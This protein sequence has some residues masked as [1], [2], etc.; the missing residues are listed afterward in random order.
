MINV[1]I[2]D[3]SPVVREFLILVLSSDPQV[4]IIGT[5][6]NGVEALEAASSKKPDV[7]TMDIHMPKMEIGRAHV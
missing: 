7:I 6:A 4:R 5:A 2:V 3:D 1:L